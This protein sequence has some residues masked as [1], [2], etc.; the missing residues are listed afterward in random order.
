MA[1]TL[2]LISSYYPANFD[3][4]DKYFEVCATRCAR[5]VDAEDNRVCAANKE[6][7]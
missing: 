4:G 7:E 6:T 2:S 3:D 1:H 5:A